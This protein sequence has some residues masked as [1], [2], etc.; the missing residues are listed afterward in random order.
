[1]ADNHHVY[2]QDSPISCG[3]AALSQIT[4]DADKVLYALATRLYHPSRGS[5]YAFAQWSDVIEV[6]SGK[7]GVI[8]SNGGKLFWRITD[9]FG[10]GGVLDSKTIENP[11]TGNYIQVFLWAVPHEEFKK[12]Y[13]EERVRRAKKL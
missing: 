4:P 5:P 11:K 12:W 7:E 2:I 8:R 9:L 6:G 3:V 10:K 1:M 13:I